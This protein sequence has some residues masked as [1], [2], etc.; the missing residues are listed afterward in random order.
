MDQV[1]AI[2]G[3]PQKDIKLGTKEI[4]SYPDLKVTFMH[5]KVSDVQ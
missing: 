4:Y 3:T 2:L 1:V 5:G